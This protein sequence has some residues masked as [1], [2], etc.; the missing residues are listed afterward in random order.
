MP[1]PIV[2][3]VG[4]PNVG[5]STL[6]NRLAEER[7]A[8]VADV[9]G[10]T[11]DRLY[12]DAEFAGREFTIVDTGGIVGERDVAVTQHSSIEFTA[13]IRAQAE[14]AIAEADSII[15]LVDVTQG[16]MPGDFEI[17]DIL[18]RT[19]KPVYLVA[20]K[21]DNQARR[22]E[23]VE[24][25]ALGLGEPIPISAHNGINTGDLLEKIVASFPKDLPHESEYPRFA[26]IGRPNVGKSSLL[27]A[28]LGQER[29]IVSEIPGTTRDAVDTMCVWRGQQLVLIDTAGLRRRGKIDVGIEKYSAM[30]AIRAIQR[31]EVALLVIDANEGILAQDQHVASYA[32]DEG[33]GIVLVVN[34]WDLVDNKLTRQEFTESLHREFDFLRF[35][36]IV[37][38]SAKFERGITQLL[39]TS[40]QVRTEWLTRVSTADINEV[41][42]DAMAEHPPLRAGRTLKLYYGS[43]TGTGPPT[44]VFFVNDKKLVHFTFERYLDNR[45]RE[46]WK[47]TGTP[48]KMIFRAHRKE[49]T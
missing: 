48:I 45:I 41:V 28:I 30:R 25:Y 31:A 46:K 39:D 47:L 1:K 7:L 6:F 27:N 20:N 22:D 49:K 36:P 35:A 23:A 8:I 44:F 16:M 40:L 2:A 12:A 34:K 21:A 38:V 15:F 9:P 19:S 32:L 37:F 5:K 33:R 3:I 13:L 11:R 4:R 18:R 14:L 10:T 17:A 29:A 26:I 42:R 43:Q 24:F